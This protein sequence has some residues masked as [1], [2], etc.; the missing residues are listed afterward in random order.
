LIFSDG[1]DWQEGEQQFYRQYWQKYV[2][3]LE[4]T[5]WAPWDQAMFACIL[6]R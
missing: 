2:L 6:A 3:L 4:Q 5:I 1:S